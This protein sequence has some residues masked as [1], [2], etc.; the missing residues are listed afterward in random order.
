MHEATDEQISDMVKNSLVGPIYRIREAIPLMKAR[1]AGDIVSISSQSVETPQPYM[2]VYAAA[3]AGLETLSKG[4]RYELRS[5][6]IRITSFQV[7]VI[8]DT[9]DGEDWGPEQRA[10]MHAAFDASGVRPLF[11]FPG[12]SARSLA[13]SVAHV[14]TAPRDVCLQYV[15]ARGT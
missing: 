2:T 9:A 14:V 7:G 10:E 1:G 4:L 11:L 8:A 3:K 15:E 5:E 12:S 13:D 6:P